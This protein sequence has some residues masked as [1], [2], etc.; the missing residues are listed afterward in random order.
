MS[1]HI[2][3][4]ISSAKHL[5]IFASVI[6]LFST[7]ACAKKEIY[8]GQSL[9]LSQH[10]FSITDGDTIRAGDYRLRM[11]Y[12]DAPEAKQVCYDVEGEPWACGDKATEHL[13]NLVG[14]GKG[15]SCDIVGQDKYKRNLAICYKGNMNINKQMVADG[16]AMAYVK[17]GSPYI[18][19]QRDA[20]FQ[21]LGMWSGTFLDPQ[22]YRSKVR[23]ESS[24]KSD[25]YN[26]KNKNKGKGKNVR[27]QRNTKNRQEL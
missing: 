21:G 6:T 17:Y 15:V 27:K 18:L 7:V 2:N 10:K 13:A 12:I 19:E 26:Q 9:I 22:V 4:A 1:Y 5:A 3:K 11:Q 8:N 24:S 16:Y 25:I 23:S 20:K 14:N